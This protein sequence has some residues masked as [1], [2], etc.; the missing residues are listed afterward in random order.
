MEFLKR[1]TKSMFNVS[2]SIGLNV[3]PDS[4]QSVLALS[5]HPLVV[6][7]SIQK[8]QLATKS[9]LLLKL[10]ALNSNNKGKAI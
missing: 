10:D 6:M 7:S 1:L 5:S 3:V 8:M 2:P 4:T 9:L